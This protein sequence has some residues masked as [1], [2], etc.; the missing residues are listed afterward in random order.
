MSTVALVVLLIST[1]AV[2]V[3]LGIALEAL[4]W[5]LRHRGEDAA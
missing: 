2:C 3:P 5:R 1:A 4:E